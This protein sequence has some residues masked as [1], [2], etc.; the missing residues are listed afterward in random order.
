MI[1]RIS[2]R[3]GGNSSVPIL[4]AV[5]IFMVLSASVADI[6]R[7]FILREQTKNAADSISLSVAQEMF[8]FDYHALDRIAESMAA[9]HK[10]ELESLDIDG[11][12]VSVTV[13]GKV[14]LLFLDRLKHKDVWTVRSG[15]SVEVIYPWD[16]RSGLCRYY[17]FN[18]KD[19]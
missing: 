6:S 16:M 15:S 5:L 1:K 17:E 13:S 4:I 12:T 19:K 18:L 10:C 7:I 2:R 8:F 11:N 14:K 9:K 3:N